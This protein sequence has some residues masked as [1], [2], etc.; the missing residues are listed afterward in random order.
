MRA[1]GIVGVSYIAFN[2]VG[3]LDAGKLVSDLTYMRNNSTGEIR[4]C[5]TRELDV[6]IRYTGN[7]Y[8]TGNPYRVQQDIT[9][10]GRLIQY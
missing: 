7:V 8:Y 1:S 5:A 9:G 4:V 3:I 6:E 2:D 10:T